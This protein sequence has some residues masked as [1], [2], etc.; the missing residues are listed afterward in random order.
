MV[1]SGEQVQTE[2][3]LG[4]NLPNQIKFV[5]LLKIPLSRY[6]NYPHLKKVFLECTS[7][8][9]E[10][11]RTRE[12]INYNKFKLQIVREFINNNFIKNKMKILI[13]IN[14]ITLC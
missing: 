6:L 13:T 2:R 11:T 14:N 3:H 1:R 9:S 4:S 5:V 8:R 10:Y 12:F 7:I